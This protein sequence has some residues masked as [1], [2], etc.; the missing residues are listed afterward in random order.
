IAY[1]NVSRFFHKPP[2]NPNFIYDPGIYYRKFRRLMKAW[3]FLGP[4]T[5]ITII[6]VSCIFMRPDIAAWI[7]LVPM[8]IYWLL[9]VLIQNKKLKSLHLIS[10]PNPTIN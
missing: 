6:I 2:K 4:T 10:N 9:L 3:T 8:N 5:H 7:I 1:L